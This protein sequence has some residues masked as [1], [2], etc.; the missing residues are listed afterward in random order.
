MDI[1]IKV[2]DLN[3]LCDGS[4]VVSKEQK[5]SF[6][7]DEMTFV[8]D[9]LSDE[10]GEYN[11]RQEHIGNTMVT[12]LINFT[13]SLG[14]GLKEPTKMATLSNGEG[15]YFAFAVHS[16]SENPRVFHYT[17]YIGPNQNN[18]GNNE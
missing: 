9:F 14:T 18:E 6:H 7:I 5:I 1:K 2:N 8:F 13:N 16:I 11:A 10:T 15:L 4:L 12:H 17:W 3:V